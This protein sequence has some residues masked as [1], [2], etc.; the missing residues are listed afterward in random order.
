M[1]YRAPWLAF[2]FASSIFL[3]ACTAQLVEV[4]EVKT[5]Q[6]EKLA[7]SKTY[8]ALKV[9][10]VK[11]KLGRNEVIGSMAD[12]ALCVPT[13]QIFWGEGENVYFSADD[14]ADIARDGIRKAGIP[15][16]DDPDVIFSS[17]QKAA[18][19]LLFGAVVQEM[20]GN[21]CAMLQHTDVRG[22]SWMKVLWQ[23]YSV[24]QG[25]VIYS[26]EWEG[27]YKQSST[28]PDR[29]RGIWLGSFRSSLQNLLADEQFRKVL[30]SHSTTSRSAAPAARTN[31][32]AAPAKLGPLNI[33]YS[34]VD[35]LKL[36]QD[37]PRV[38]EALVEVVS[39]IMPGWGFFI[40]SDG[41][42][43]TNQHLVGEAA[44]VRVRLANGEETQAKVVRRDAQRDVA[45]LKVK[46]KNIF[47]L[48]VAAGKARAGVT[49]FLAA[50]GLP[51]GSLSGVVT[52]YMELS[53]GLTYLVG[54]IALPSWGTGLPLLDGDGSVV[55]M[56]GRDPDGKQGENRGAMFI[57]ML[58]VFK[59]L[60]MR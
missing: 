47:A 27:F 11:L 41:Y 35:D 42:L 22:D 34:Q 60:D 39:P 14:L 20:R 36:P 17:G 46:A 30:A 28:V 59:S 51:G 55:A 53:D 50:S 33:N 52:G 56:A 57:P 10:A 9:E 2:L 19:D 44:Q 58:Q 15:L 8:P 1:K 23:L 32:P 37:A 29:G 24:S 45:L 7:E 26:K 54:D 21:L 6:P 4:P 48:P 25:K 40:S 18:P 12:N 31:I 38:E 13:D 43:L 49:I 3:S 16:T 5:A